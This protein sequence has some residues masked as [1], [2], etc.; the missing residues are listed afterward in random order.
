MKKTL[1]S[2]DIWDTILKRHCAPKDT[3]R[4]SVYIFLLYY[5]ITQYINDILNNMFQKENE[6][7][8]KNE[9][10]YIFD[11][12]YQ[13]VKKIKH[14]DF[15][16]IDKKQLKKIWDNIYIN[17]EKKSTFPNKKILELINKDKGEKIYI[18]DFYIEKKLL[19]DILS[20]H[21][22]Y[23][24]NG[25]V[26]CDENK[27]KYSGDLYEKIKNLYHTNSINWIHTGDNKISDIKIA[28]SLKIKTRY[29]NS[30]NLSNKIKK[31]LPI[32]KQHNDIEN[33]SFIL[34][35]FSKFILEE[36]KKNK[37]NDIYFFTREGVTFK[38][39]F[40]LFLNEISSNFN[41]NFNIKTHIVYVSRTATIPLRLDI[42]D[43]YLGF[44]DAILQY[45]NDTSTFLS[46]F[47]LSKKLAHLSEKYKKIEDL[48]KNEKDKKIL[49]ELIS[50][51]KDLAINYLL[52]IGFFEKNKLIV[53]IGWRGSIQD[54]ISCIDKKIKLGCYLG[55]FEFFQHQNKAKKEGYIFNNN[56]NK[57]NIFHK[58]VDFWETIFNAKGGSVTS[59]VN[60]I[61]KKKINKDE[62]LFL[63]E[64]INVQE[65]IY[66]EAKHQLHDIMKN[67]LSLLDIDNHAK[68]AYK[69]ISTKPSSYLAD[70]Y[71]S[72]LQNESYG[73]NSFKRKYINITMKSLIK[74]F[75]SKKEKESISNLIKNN[76]WRESILYSKSTS[77]ST[78]LSALIIK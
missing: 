61:P 45:G 32:K 64:I 68:F 25:F 67:K 14:L 73:L 2:Y 48:L 35:G 17:V 11:L 78:K 58:G 59:Y 4:I 69:K 8:N 26:S 39:F 53:D 18:S 27:N 24:S 51:K 41:I 65:M 33:L 10:Y 75:F 71:L 21:N 62:E 43:S 23:F 29:V 70:L 28:R 54:N 36:C 66:N 6:Y 77:L 46:F 76:G 9:E 30:F 74:S 34:I 38:R 42:N 52:S 12:L 63:N 44:K 50:N 5:G 22:I 57:E 49:I 19:D 13:E 20:H 72:S 7:F 3:I 55:L 37:V 56:T 16:N 1:Y 40:D 15:T 47:N 31:L 60:N